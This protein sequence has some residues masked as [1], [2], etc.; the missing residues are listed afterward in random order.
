MSSAVTMFLSV[1]A[2]HPAFGLNWGYLGMAAARSAGGVVQCGFLVGFVR[3]YKLED[4]IWRIHP[5][6][7]AMNTN[8]RLHLPP[9]T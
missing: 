1:I 5:G 4:V 8:H 6:T 2:V 9:P 7:V 3:Y